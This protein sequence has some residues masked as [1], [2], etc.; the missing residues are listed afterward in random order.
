MKEYSATDHKKRICENT[1]RQLFREKSNCYVREL[2]YMGG[3]DIPA[4]TEDIFI[5]IVGNILKKHTKL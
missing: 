5:E 4:M 2:P 1:A 3:E